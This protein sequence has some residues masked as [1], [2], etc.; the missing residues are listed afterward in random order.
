[1]KTQLREILT[2]GLQKAS[3]AAAMWLTRP[4]TAWMACECADL[5]QPAMR[6]PP[7]RRWRT[8][9][10]HQSDSVLDSVSKADFESL[11]V[12]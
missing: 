11:R 1:M 7:P 10:G 6:L 12:A 5:T 9:E 4:L 3:E 8:C 2:T